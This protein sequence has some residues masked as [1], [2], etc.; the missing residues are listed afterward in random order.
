MEGEQ[1]VRRSISCAGACVVYLM[2]WT[3]VAVCCWA[4]AASTAST[5]RVA[6]RG[7]A[8]LF[9]VMPGPA[10]KSGTIGTLLGALDKQAFTTTHSIFV[11]GI[12]SQTSLAPIVVD[13]VR[14]LLGWRMIAPGALPEDAKL[15][16]DFKYS[17]RYRL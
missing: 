16:A 13:G 6:T 1:E 3:P 4:A 2:S 11:D 14:W 7:D 9:A 5:A 10:S 8:A 17:E 12:L 15:P